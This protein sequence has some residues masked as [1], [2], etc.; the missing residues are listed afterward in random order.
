MQLS[1]P[2]RCALAFGVGLLLAGTASAGAISLRWDAL[3]GVT[4]YR[5]HYGTS[6]GSY[7]SVRDVGSATSTTLT[8][9]S[10]CTNYYIAVKG[11]NSQGES[12][13]YSNEVAGWSRP[14][15]SSATPSSVRQGDQLTLNVNGAN[16]QPGASFEYNIVGLPTSLDGDP[17][18]RIGNVSVT[19]CNLIQAQLTIEP[20]AAGLRAME[21]GSFPV[22]VKVVN[23][24]TVY[25]CTGGATGCS[26]SVAPL[27][28]QF[29][30]QRA[31]VN[32]SDAVTNN[33]ID[34]KDLV[35]LAYSFGTGEG[36]PKHNSDA[37]LNGDGL[38]DGEDLAYLA[39]RFGGCWTGSAWAAGA[40]P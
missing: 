19:S 4:G 10:N 21:V 8:N 35:W 33:R 9:L 28:V 12:A 38:V 24:D 23:P 27:N 5:V 22:T 16:F 39:T 11:Y 20:T 14:E 26:G 15:F 13:T 36:Q 34:G 40:C 37:D 3:S 18:V 6:P 32:D 2:V 17:L 29:R 30:E 31:D 1:R 7:T 25:G